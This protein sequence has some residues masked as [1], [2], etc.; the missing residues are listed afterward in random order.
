M[1][2]RSLTTFIETFKNKDK[3]CSEEIATMYRQSDGYP[4]GMGK[5][6]AE[7]LID[8]RL[9][10][11]ISI[12]EKGV[13]YNGMGCLAAQVVA[14]FK[15]GAG[16]IYLQRKNKNSGEEYRYII[17]GDFDTKTIT[18]EVNEVGYMEGNKYINKT[19]CIFSGTPREF[20]DSQFAK[21]E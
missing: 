3:D 13:V 21:R 9:V 11:G 5:D 17:I 4:S 6:L 15:K 19:R 14:H 10:N 2:T 12:N 8:G 7:F 20:M 1:S 16:G 18:M